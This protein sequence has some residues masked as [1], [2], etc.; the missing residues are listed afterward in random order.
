MSSLRHFPGRAVL[1]C[2]KME[3]TISVIVSVYNVAEVLEQTLSCIANQSYRNL[4]IILVDD[5]STDDSGAIC[6][7][8]AQTDSRGKVIHKANGGQCSAK[9]AGREIATGS[10]LFFPDADDLFNPDMIRLLYEAI[11]LDPSCD[12]SLAGMIMTEKRDPSLITS[13]PHDEFNTIFLSRDDLIRGLFERADDRFVFG[14]NKLYKKNL[15]KGITHRNYPRCE[16]FDLNFRVFLR[17]NKAAYIDLPLYNWIRRAGSKTRQSNSRDLHF[18]CKTASLCANWKNLP[19]DALKY[20]LYLLDTLYRTM[21][22]WEEWSRKSDNF[23]YA[24]AMCSMYIKDTFSKYLFCKRIGAGKK[25]ACLTMLF[26]PSLAHTI[27][28]ATNNAR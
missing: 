4:E 11:R 27:M 19:Q 24:K 14:W 17:T 3:E 23:D 25:L 20:E 28:K 5:G 13:I 12:I 7:A 18:E 16:D 6:D 15:L 1:N 22:L 2:I 26:F 10:Y 21:V 9:D 8:F